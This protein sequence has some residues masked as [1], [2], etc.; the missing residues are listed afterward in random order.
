MT[1]MK[2]TKKNRAGGSAAAGGINYQAAVTA[3]AFV[4]MARGLPLEWTDSGSD[5]PTAVS[6]EQGSTGDDL[7]IETHD[8]CV[9]SVQVKKGINAGDAILTELVDLAAEAQGNPKSHSILVVDPHSSGVV[10]KDLAI[11]VRRIGDGRVD[12]LSRSG[13]VL[14]AKLK[15]RGLAPEACARLRIKTI[16]ALA[17]DAAHVDQAKSEIE[18][19]GLP[20]K[21]GWNALYADAGR[22]IEFRGR[23]T[24]TSFVSLLTTSHSATA[25]SPLY[26]ARKLLE[27][28]LQACSQFTIFGI[29]HPLRLEDAWLR[30]KLARWTRTDLSD[31]GLADAVQ[32]YYDHRTSRADTTFD[33]EGLGWY[34]RQCVVVGGPG[35]GKS[36]LLR[37]LRVSYASKSEVALMVSL[38]ELCKRVSQQGS[39]FEEG[40]LTL[41]LDTTGVLPNELRILG[42]QNVTWLLDGLDECGDLIELVAQSIGQFASAH[43]GARIIIST[44]PIGYET[45]LL[46]H[47]RHYK[48]LTAEGRFA[49][50]VA[51]LIWSVDSLNETERGAAAKF[52]ARQLKSSSV[53]KLAESSPML[54]SMV[55]SLAFSQ[56]AVGSTEASFYDAVLAKVH[57]APTPRRP[58]GP[59]RTVLDAVLHQTGLTLME[60][61]DS[62]CGTVEQACAEHL[63]SALECSAM[64][65]Q[66]LSEVA[67]GHW[68][69]LG[70]L[71]RI[72]HQGLEA[73][74]FVHRTFQEFAAAK[75]LANQNGA[76]TECTLRAAIQKS[77]WRKV[78]DF[79]WDLGMSQ[80]II[81]LILTERGTDKE[82][83]HLALKLV[84][85]DRV[86]ATE[87][88]PT[89]WKAMWASLDVLSVRDA[90]ALGETAVE[91]AKWSPEN[92]QAANQNLESACMPARLTAWAMLA[93]CDPVSI[94]VER[95]IAFLDAFTQF[96]RARPNLHEGLDLGNPLHGLARTLILGVLSELVRRGIDHRAE[97]VVTRISAGV[98]GLLFMG[99][100][101][102]LAEAG[103]PGTTRKTSR[104][105]IAD[106]FSPVNVAHRRQEKI[107]L[108]NLV[109]E[110]APAAIDD[111]SV[112]PPWL[113]L[114]GLLAGTTHRGLDNEPLN[115]EG[116]WLES[117]RHVLQATL[118]VGGFDKL[119]LGREAAHLRRVICEDQEDSPAYYDG[120]LDLDVELDWTR[121]KRLPLDVDLIE[122]AIEHPSLWI[123]L[124]AANLLG[125]CLEGEQLD[126]VVCR[127][128]RRSGHS[129]LRL[130]GAFAKKIGARSR[131]WI[132]DSLAEQLQDGCRYLFDALAQLPPPLQWCETT[133]SSLSR[134]LTF[135][136][137]TAMAAS[138]AASTYI[139]VARDRIEELLRVAY[140]HWLANPPHRPAPQIVPPDPRADILKALLSCGPQPDLL[141]AALT[142]VLSDVRALAMDSALSLMGE[143]DAFRLSVAQ[144]IATESTPP[145]LLRAALDRRLPFGT[146]ELTLLAGCLGSADPKV[147]LSA[148][149]LLDP[150]YLSRQ[151]ID[152]YKRVLSDD[153]IEQ[154][155]V[156]IESM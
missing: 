85:R 134:G 127:L 11:A 37:R 51:R 84:G 38:R 6:A 52:A 3:I 145:G 46:K 116:T 23:R 143:D 22:L 35:M 126:A 114:S 88:W 60:R 45:Q 86:L 40:L 135:G 146:E 91:A 9:I 69:A 13:R 142:D 53:E 77:D 112:Q 87:A 20:R 140:A 93:R 83:L 29:P 74:A 89:L 103:W 124:M 14:L 33:A 7:R 130:A 57:A 15:A 120:M 34:H 27:V 110:A 42:L 56:M 144:R 122:K 97:T 95:F 90:Y 81:R 67:L 30:S 109:C 73:Y 98:P 54:A 133:A 70:I 17:D 108:L 141:L 75:L 63:R 119:E 61:P 47:W 64:H 123:G 1:A 153:P 148:I 41:A 96:E 82:A 2:A 121:A 21:E 150:I 32:K 58:S 28:T 25:A 72:R 132:E 36:T 105:F 154:I 62:D 16:H 79:A 111:K 59:T 50:Q 4:H 24:A 55:A 128:L 137:Y 155:R 106:F 31:I 18:R 118:T 107:D 76:A 80:E 104:D 44:R 5:T 131:P 129:T 66:T 125:E 8:G 102:L 99:M 139:P 149:G 101:D 113:Q 147:R 152:A 43:Q 94:D 19:L 68:E 71:E 10:R 49:D 48:L 12:D 65:A 136:P 117:I 156:S 138:K 26:T 92:V 115:S 78:L 151:Q 100:E 39:T